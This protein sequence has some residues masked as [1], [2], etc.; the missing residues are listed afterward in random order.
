MPKRKRPVTVGNIVF[1]IFFILSYP[2]IALFSAAVT[3]LV[4]IFSFPSKLI[5]FFSKIK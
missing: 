5:A 1:E 4:W 3:L 2:F